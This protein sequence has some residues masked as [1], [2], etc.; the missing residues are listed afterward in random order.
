MAINLLPLIEKRVLTLEKSQKKINVILLFAFFSLLFFCF[1]LFSFKNYTGS[2][3]VSAKDL[4]LQKEAALKG[5]DFEEFRF[6]T[7]ELNQNLSRLRNFWQ[8]QFL[9]TPV[10]E[11]LAFLTPNTLY[12]TSLSFDQKELG[13]ASILVNGLAQTRGALF[14]FKQNLE[15]EPGFVQVSFSPFSWVKP[16]DADFSFSLNYLPE[17]NVE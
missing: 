4:I 3:V 10:L 15:A 7:T 11:K 16:N 12:F 14:Y 2:Q 1:L 8:K 5:T 17:N 13:Q 9:I 6:K